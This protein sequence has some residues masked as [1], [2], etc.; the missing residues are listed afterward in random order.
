MEDLG[1]W[2]FRLVGRFVEFSVAMEQACRSCGLVWRL[3]WN[4]TGWG[5][6]R[7]HQGS[8]RSVELSVVTSYAVPVGEFIRLSCALVDV[9]G[10]WFV[11]RSLADQAAAKKNPRRR[12]PRVCL[13]LLS[14][15]FPPCDVCLFRLLVD[16]RFEMNLASSFP[17]VHRIRLCCLGRLCSHAFLPRRAGLCDLSSRFAFLFSFC[18]CWGLFYNAQLFCFVHHRHCGVGKDKKEKGA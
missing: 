2:R 3:V 9:L 1:R 8:A 16:C 15:C 10:F 5:R 17:C 11:S 4:Q 18:C 13:V 7:R 14:L 6:E 12:S